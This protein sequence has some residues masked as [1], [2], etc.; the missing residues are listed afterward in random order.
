MPGFSLGIKKFNITYLNCILS[1]SDEMH[2]CVLFFFHNK[3]D[4][5]YQELLQHASIFA[6][7]NITYT[8]YVTDES[9]VTN[10]YSIC[11]TLKVSQHQHRRNLMLECSRAILGTTI[12]IQAPP[13]MHLMIYEVDAT[14]K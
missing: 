1:Y 3:A 12:E 6:G 13:H 5:I 4:R 8:V 14:C 11:N 7:A 10:T 2:I 9:L